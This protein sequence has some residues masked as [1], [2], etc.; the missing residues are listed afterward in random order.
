MLLS[1]N[2]Y[3]RDLLGETGSGFLTACCCCVVWVTFLN[4]SGISFPLV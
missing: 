1:K 4:L 2:K 3:S